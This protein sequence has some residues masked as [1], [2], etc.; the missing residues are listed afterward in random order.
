MKKTGLS[1]FDWLGIIAVILTMGVGATVFVYAN[2]DPKG[3][4]DKTEARL[5][6][7]FGNRIDRV[8][9]LQTTMMI[10]MGIRVPPPKAPPHE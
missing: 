8:E 2:F 9:Q 1:T 10:E 4:A 5:N 6:K 7:N 3:E